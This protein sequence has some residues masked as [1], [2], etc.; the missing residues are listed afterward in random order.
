MAKNVVGCNSENF[1]RCLFASELDSVYEVSNTFTPSVKIRMGQLLRSA[2]ELKKC[3]A[4]KEDDS[5]MAHAMTNF[6]AVHVA[7]FKHQVVH[8]ATMEQ[9]KKKFIGNY[10]FLPLS[11]DIKMLAEHLED[12]C[13]RCIE[14]YEGGRKNAKRLGLGKGLLILASSSMC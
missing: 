4:I 7:D 12:E 10:D 13:H 11:K 14:A 6:I 3:I 5:K 2:M 1:C 8:R 9:E